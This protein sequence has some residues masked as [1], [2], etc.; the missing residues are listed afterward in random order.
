MSPHRPSRNACSHRANGTRRTSWWRS[1]RTWRAILL[2]YVPFVVA[3]HLAWEIAQ[4]PLYTIW[5][6]G[7]E[8]EIAFAV[9]HCT[10][11]DLLIAVSALGLAL[12]I[13]GSRDFV[14]WNLAAIAALTIAIG[15]G[16][17]VL[18][19]RMN[20]ALGYWAYAASMPIVPVLGVGLAPFAQWIAVPL[21]TF[22]FLSRLRLR[23]DRS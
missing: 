16:Y 20:V 17:T 13:T 6:E 19:E 21:A 3:A 15:L 7:T 12:L 9:G 18:S 8:G 11:G 22:W 1:G 2:G 14:D 5:T 23:S 10:G 4:L